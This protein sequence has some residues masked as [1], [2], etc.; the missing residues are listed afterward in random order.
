V[1]K[2]LLE[3]YKWQCKIADRISARGFKVRVPPLRMAHTPEQIKEFSDGG[4]IFVEHADGIQE[5]RLEVK[6]IKREWTSIA[7]HPFRDHI[8]VERV[9]TWEAKKERDELPA[10]II[11]V[12]KIT[13]VAIIIP[14]ALGSTGARSKPQTKREN[15]ARPIFT[16]RA[17]LSSTG[18]T[19]S[20]GYLRSPESKKA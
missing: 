9:A 3:G 13:G 7:D 6:S 2:E 4:D 20:G 14:A 12:S 5:I 8:T 18:I 16:R 17:T 15:G 10:A 19:S 1:H 11:L